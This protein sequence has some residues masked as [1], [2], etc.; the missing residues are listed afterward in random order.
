MD[1]RF[2][3]LHTGAKMPLMGLGT[4]LSPDTSELIEIIKKAV[5]EDGYRQIDTASLYGN[6]E[7]IGKALKE[8][9]AAG[10]KR[11]DLFIVT[12]LWREDYAIDKIE[13]AIKKSLEKLQLDYIDLYLVH[14]TV[15]VFDY[16]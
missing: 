14:W 7:A 1:S 10:I 16:T 6:E 4:F 8:C 12:K 5:I 13:N 9:F 3:T 11:E 2:A 15:P